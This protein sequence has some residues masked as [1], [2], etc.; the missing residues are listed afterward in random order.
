MPNAQDPDS[1]E[2]KNVKETLG[3]YSEQNAKG[4]P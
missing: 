2:T 1:L 3:F 4:S